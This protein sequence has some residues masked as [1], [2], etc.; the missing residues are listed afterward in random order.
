MANHI[1][2]CD[3]HHARLRLVRALVTAALASAPMTLLAQGQAAWRESKIVPLAAGEWSG[4]RLADGQ[5]DV[6]GHW[7]N[8][9]GNHNNLTNPQGGGADG[10]AAAPPEGPGGARPGRG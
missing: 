6:Q 4:A 10:P 7:S 9:I 3:S 8:T 5:P 2:P 1:A